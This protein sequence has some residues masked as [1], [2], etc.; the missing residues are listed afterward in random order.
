MEDKTAE[1]L[2]SILFFQ[3]YL[4]S[5]F[6]SQHSVMQFTV[7][8]FSDALH[9]IVQV[10]R[11]Y[12]KLL[13]ELLVL[14]NYFLFVVPFFSIIPLWLQ[15]IIILYFLFDFLW[16]LFLLLTVYSIIILFCPYYI[17]TFFKKETAINRK[18]VYFFKLLIELYFVCTLRFELALFITF[19]LT[20]YEIFFYIKRIK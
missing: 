16:I 2:L 15:L 19:F 13:Y 7:G 8:F 10:S 17:Y 6:C 4:F 12:V 18:K 9:F 14:M 5:D 11:F 3:L 1:S 20:A